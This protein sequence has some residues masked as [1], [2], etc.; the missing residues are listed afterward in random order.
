MS[1]MMKSGIIVV[2]L[3]ATVTLTWGAANLAMLSTF[4]F[5]EHLDV[6]K[7]MP[8]L[9]VFVLPIV[10]VAIHRRQGRATMP[11]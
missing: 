9:L 3:C 7:A 1:G 5:D 8:L 10:A 2:S 4:W 11:D 6:A